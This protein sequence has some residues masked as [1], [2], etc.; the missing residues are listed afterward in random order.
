MKRSVMI[1]TTAT[2]FALV[3][4]LTLCFWSLS[5]LASIQLVSA[6]IHRP[7]VLG[8]PSRPPFPTWVVDLHW[9]LFGEHIADVDNRSD[10]SIV[11]FMLG[12]ELRDADG[13]GYTLDKPRFR[14]LMRR[15]VCAAPRDIPTPAVISRYARPESLP[16]YIGALQ[17]CGRIPAGTIDIRA[18]VP[19]AGK[20]QSSGSSN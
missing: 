12:A 20:G 19:Q 4:A 16:V 3:V 5:S 7:S 18:A 15:Y 9:R 2:L 6:Q 1:I 17:S 14:E 13:N 10:P 8:N 11:L